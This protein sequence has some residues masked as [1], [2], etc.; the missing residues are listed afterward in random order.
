MH[1]PSSSHWT[2]AWLN[3]KSFPLEPSK[4]VSSVWVNVFCPIKCPGNDISCLL[5]S[6]VW[7]YILFE[8]KTIIYVPNFSRDQ[9]VGMLL[10]K[11]GNICSKKKDEKVI[12]F[13]RPN[14]KSMHSLIALPLVLYFLIW[15]SRDVSSA[16]SPLPPVSSQVLEYILLFTLHTG[17]NFVIFDTSFYV[18]L[19][20]T[21]YIY[22]FV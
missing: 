22:H 17:L 19:F 1:L 16:C 12:T 4:F 7:K 18:I 9:S 14:L 5:G 2:H 13:L 3:S 21:F 8:Q 15:I 6:L 20:V 10:N 11:I